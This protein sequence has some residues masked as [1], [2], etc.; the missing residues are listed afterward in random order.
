[1]VQAFAEEF[2]RDSD[3]TD[4]LQI[5]RKLTIYEQFYAKILYHAPSSI[6]LTK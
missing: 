1:M 6:Y 4:D 5:V 3:T 2:K